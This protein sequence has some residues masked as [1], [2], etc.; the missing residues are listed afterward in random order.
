MVWERAPADTNARFCASPII[1]TSPTSC[2]VRSRYPV[3]MITRWWRVR[4]PNALCRELH[5]AVRQRVRAVV[6]EHAPGALGRRAVLVHVARVQERVEHPRQDDLAGAAHS[7]AA[8]ALLER[9]A[10]ER[11]AAADLPALA[12]RP[13]VDASRSRPNNRP[14]DS[15]PRR[16]DR[17]LD[18]PN[19]T[20]ILR[21]RTSISVG[22]RSL[23][24]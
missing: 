11:A 9:A 15:V 10:R 12:L 19:K 23:Q 14:E 3:A 18:Q 16:A 17:A 4:H 22:G 6:H 20:F 7:Q 13:N 8:D 21:L 1:I 2:C 24:V 5:T